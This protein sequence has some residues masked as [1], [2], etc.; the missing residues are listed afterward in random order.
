M[1]EP[2]Y[3]QYFTEGRS[4]SLEVT[5]STAKGSYEVM[6]YQM[7]TWGEKQSFSIYDGPENDGLE[8]NTTGSIYVELDRREDVLYLP[9]ECIYKADGNTYVY[10]LDDQNMKTICWVETGL[11][12]DRYT[13]IVS[14]LK[15][16]DTVVKR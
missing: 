4:V 1:E 7:S 6:P 3:A 16:G 12:G 2:D 5:Y 15:E 14:G 8:V 13:E 9:K 11:V 10:V